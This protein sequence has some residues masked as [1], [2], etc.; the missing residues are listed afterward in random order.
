MYEYAAK[1]VRVVDG[2]TVHL[3]LDLGFYA[4]RLGQSYRL[5]RVNAP[6]L[7]TVEGKAAKTA[8][9]TFLVGKTLMA[10]TQKSDNFGR[11]LA[12]LYADNQNVSDWLV[13]NG[14]AAYKAY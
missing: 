10:H 5:L 4:W 13:T 11:F 3:D 2:D 8:L 6:E 14:F 9:E 12:E 1:L 7:N